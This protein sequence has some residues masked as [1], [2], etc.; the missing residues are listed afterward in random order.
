MAGKLRRK[1]PCSICR[2][3]FQPDVRQ[4]GRQKTCSPDCKKELHRRH[5]EKW[6]KKNK[7]Y[8]KNN[9]LDKVIETIEAKQSESCQTHTDF[10]ELQSSKSKAK[11]ILP[12]EII[13]R[14]YGIK[15][16]IILRYIVCQVSNQTRQRAAGSP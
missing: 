12:L 10:H 13:A 8:P 6:N 11:P 5:C 1:R 9:Y 16:M 14:E 2:K 3:W 15:T 4:K 7:E